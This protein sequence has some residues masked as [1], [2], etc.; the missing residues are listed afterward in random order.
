MKKRYTI[1]MD[2]GTL[3]CRAVLLDVNTGKA[4]PK[5]CMYVYPHAILEEIGG[6]KLPSDYAL[7]DPCDYIEGLEAIIRGVLENNGIDGSEV[8]GIGIDVTDCTLIPVDKNGTPLAFDERFKN[9]PHAYVKMW[10]HHGGEKYMD[11]VRGEAERLGESF[12]SRN[13]TGISCEILFPKLLETVTEAPEVY[14][15]ADRIMHMGDFLVRQL[16]GKDAHSSSYAA[17][18]EGWDPEL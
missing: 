4:L 15:A 9:E 10:K 11:R 1:G 17:I 8:E 6:K 7:E 3:S 13:G 18:K 5:D 12:V 14:T 16:T 2:F